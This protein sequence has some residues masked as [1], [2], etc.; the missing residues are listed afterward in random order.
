MPSSVDPPELL[1]PDAAAWRSWLEQHHGEPAGVFLVLTK[2]GGRTTTLTYDDALTEALCFGWIDGQVRSRDEQTFRQRFTPRRARSPW[3]AR[4]VDIVERLIA[5]GRMRPAGQAAIDAAKADGR[6]DAAYRQAGAELP[7]DFAAAVAAV[8]AAQAMLGVLTAQNRFA[9][10]FRLSQ[11]RTAAT[12]ERRI[13]EYVAMLARG[14]TIY[15]QR[16]RPEP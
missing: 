12:R 9:M 11:L 15:P 16:R 7:P 10:I 2:K 13:A 8:P 3:S 1:L 6:F 14:E 5:E 4:N